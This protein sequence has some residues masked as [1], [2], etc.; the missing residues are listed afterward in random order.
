MQNRLKIYLLTFL[1]L[2]PNFTGASEARQVP[3]IEEWNFCQNQT[4]NLEEAKRIEEVAGR[5]G[6]IEFINKKCGYRPVVVRDNGRLELSDGDCKALFEWSKRGICAIDETTALD[7]L[8]RTMSPRVFDRR[9]YSIYCED[10]KESVNIDKF[11]SFKQG[12]C[13]V[14]GAKN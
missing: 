6:V 13:G 14:E 12:V 3:N 7:F 11:L 8:A 10:Q 4:A 9:K 1:L 2:S 5:A